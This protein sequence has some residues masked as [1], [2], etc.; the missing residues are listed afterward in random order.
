MMYGW[1]DFCSV[2][3]IGIDGGRKFIQNASNIF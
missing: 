3:G 1:V 2:F